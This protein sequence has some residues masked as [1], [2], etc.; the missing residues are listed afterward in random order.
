MASGVRLRNV[1]EDDLP[2]FFEQQMD[3]DANQMAAFPARDWDAF[4]AHWT[5]I[6]A[7]YT[8]PV[9][10]ILLGEHVAGNI[11]SWQRDGNRLVG[12]WIGKSYWGCGIATMALTE[13]LRVVTE[14]PLYA[15]VAKHNVGS[16]RVLE[17]CG[18]SMC[19]D[20]TE[21]S[22]TPSDQVEEFVFKLT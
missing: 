20:V 9:R 7:D 17:K 21:T 4:M 3:S 2:I 10:T 1:T 15:H 8:L 6:L 13:F 12:Y 14:R 11:V 16:I 5:K 19:E 22:E 18:F